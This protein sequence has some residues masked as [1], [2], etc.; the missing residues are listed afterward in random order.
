MIDFTPIGTVHTKA[1][2]VPHSWT[3]SDV[4]GELVIDKA[5]VRGIRDIQPG[6]KIVVIFA[7]HRSPP[8]TPGDLTQHPRGEPARPEKGVFSICS[9]IRP[10]P[11]GMSVLIVTAVKD[12]IIN[13][14]GLDM[15]DGTPILDIKPL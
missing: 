2:K 3:V 10:N 14:K 4:Q 8:F 1:L 13:V 5:Y 12:N 6:E 9:P 11:I 7:F 15:I